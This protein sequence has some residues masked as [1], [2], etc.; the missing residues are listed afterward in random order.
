[1]NSEPNDHE[2][3]A[4]L[5]LS[6]EGR[7]QHFLS[8]IVTFDQVWMA[9]DDEGV[10]SFKHEGCDALPVWPARRYAEHVLREEFPEARYVAVKLRRWLEKT[11]SPV[12]DAEDVVI[13]VFPDAE[14]YGLQVWV[15]DMIA[16]IEAELGT[17]LESL[18]GFDPD[19][20]EI[21]LVELLKP[22]MRAS[23]RAKPKGKLP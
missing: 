10:L 21:D 9:E 16:D 2:F 15:K 1:M 5:N 7:Y 13:A 19:A 3:E 20:E 18:P 17:R 12:K 22:A 11:L 6:P 14:G 8:R 23:M 4:V